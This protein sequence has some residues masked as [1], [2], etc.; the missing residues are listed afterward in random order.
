MKMVRKM[1]RRITISILVVLIS[2]LVGLHKWL[3]L[4]YSIKYAL[5][6]GAKIIFGPIYALTVCFHIKDYF[7]VVS[8]AV[9]LGLFCIIQSSFVLKGG[10]L[11][12][13]LALVFWLLWLANGL[14]MVVGSG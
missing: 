14:Y 12:A 10:W 11:R 7:G 6:Q 3:S 2:F 4:G 8:H 13:C 5:C 9:F 1:I